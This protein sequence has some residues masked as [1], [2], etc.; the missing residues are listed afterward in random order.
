VKKIIESTYGNSFLFQR[1][2]DRKQKYFE[3]GK[4]VS[5]CIYD[6]LV[7]RDVKHRMFG[8]SVRIVFSD[9]GKRGIKPTCA[10]YFLKTY[11]II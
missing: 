11:L 7:F 2:M 3:Q 9:D 1:G 4:L 10:L 8:G 5:D 6:M